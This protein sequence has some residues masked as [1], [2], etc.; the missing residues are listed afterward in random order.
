[1]RL[2][3]VAILVP[4][5]DPAIAFFE[6]IGFS[7]EI[8]EDQGRKRWVVVCAPNG[9]RLLIARAEGAPLDHVGRQFGGRVGLF[10][11]TDDFARDHARI[12]AAGGTFEEAPREEAY[13]QVAVW[14]DPWGNRWD[15]IEPS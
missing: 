2:A 8:D 12:A 5:Y 11:E 4:D 14:R 3:L 6:N 10:L 13:G 1:M 15:L 9:G 7:L